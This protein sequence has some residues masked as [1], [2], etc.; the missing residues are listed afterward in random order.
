[1]ANALLLNVQQGLDDATSDLVWR[2]LG[3][4]HASVRLVPQEL[5][6]RAYV[7]SIGRAMPGLP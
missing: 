6:V 7:T 4:D 2:L 1:M 3:V 5:T